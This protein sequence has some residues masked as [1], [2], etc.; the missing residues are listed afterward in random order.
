MNFLCAALLLLFA[1]SPV[2]GINI[3]LELTGYVPNGIDMKALKDGYTRI[4]K[5]VGLPPEDNRHPL[6]IVFYKV[7]EQRKTGIR[8]PEWGGGGAIGGDTIVIPV[9]RVSAFYRNDLNRILLHEMVH[10]ALDRAYGHLRLPRW[11]HEGMAMTLSGEISFEEQV[12]L[13][14][15]ILT[16]TLIPLD[17]IEYM[18]RFVRERASIAYSQ[19]HFAVDFLLTTYG[20]DL[21]PELLAASRKTRD[22]SVACFN[23]FGLTTPEL[24]ILLK[25]EMNRKYR[26]FYLFAD[27]ALVWLGI[28]FLAVMAFIVTIIR[29]RKKRARLEAEELG[30][31][32]MV[33]EAGALGPKSGMKNE[34]CRN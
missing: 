12:L 13:S 31:E 10:C 22:F 34:E 27:Y 5:S 18:N 3:V 20:L 23:V 2:A 11:F 8:L 29:N 4:S 25:K 30:E 1:V 17:S 15:A 26:I 7:S 16:R 14:R 9:D 6:T 32:S 33:E 28:L 21:I 24:E 19:S